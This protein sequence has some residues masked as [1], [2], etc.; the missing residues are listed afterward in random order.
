VRLSGICVVP[1]LN[2]ANSVD[3]TEGNANDF[4]V[5]GHPAWGA[6]WNI[7]SVWLDYL[8]KTD[9]HGSRPEHG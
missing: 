5:D 6:R 3:K 2:K 4:N 7:T 8:P 9:S 1:F